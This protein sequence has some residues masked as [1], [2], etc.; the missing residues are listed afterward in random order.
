MIPPGNEPPRRP[1]PSG[2]E[3]AAPPPS[4][5]ARTLA[6]FKWAFLTAAG[7]ALLSLLT[8]MVLSRLLTPSEFG[9]LAIALVFVTLADTVG[10][11]SI[12]PALIQRF[13]LT[14]RHVAT[15]FT[16]SIAFGLLLAAALWGLAPPIGLLIGEPGVPPVLRTLSLA[17]VLTA[18][19]V[20]SEHL[21]HRELRF[22]RLMTA[23]ILSQALGGGLVAIVLALEGHGVWAL[24]W[25]TLAR[26]GLFALAVVAWRPPPVALR[27]ARREAGELLGVGGGF[28]AVALLNVV[29]HQGVHLIVARSLGA[30]ALGLYT[31]GARLALVPTG[32]GSVLRTVL[33]LA[34]AQRQRRTERLQAV[35]LNGV[36]LLFLLAFPASLMIAV[37]AP[38][39]VAVV[40]GRQWD[41]AVP[42]LRVLALASAFQACNAL[43]VS[44]IRGI[45]AVYRESWRRALYLPLLVGGSW[46]GSRWGIAGVAAAVACAW[47]VRHLLLAHLTLSLLGLPWRRLLGRHLPALWTG[48]WAAA[49]LWLTAGP[50]RDAALPA[51]AALAI[52]LAAWGAAA[53]AAA[54][55]APPFA[56]PAFPH[57]ALAQLPF[58]RMG[59]PGRHLRAVLVR[60]ARRWPAPP[61]SHPP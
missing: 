37:T 31:R 5:T 19:A 24:V 60:L 14:E 58:D 52:E 9:Q 39:I 55:F 48:A 7:R 59:R 42:V 11:R 12:G 36:E 51:F 25:G 15:A 45:G 4:L 53:A 28:S 8:V 26:Q 21:L 23:G 1:G 50:V 17:P 10:R 6:G 22:N 38:E 61:S 13:D 41:G 43:H 32:L 47:T 35:H 57:W 27:L 49:A 29:A 16:L 20:V 54:W 18:I 56:R 30:A 3:D 46:L 40:L 34:M 33:F 2:D 44:V